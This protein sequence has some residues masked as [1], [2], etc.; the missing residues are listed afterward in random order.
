MDVP[1]CARRRI[2]VHGVESCTGGATTRLV[3]IDDADLDA[4][5]AARVPHRPVADRVVPLLS[6]GLV[7]T[8]AALDPEALCS[9]RSPGEYQDVRA[10]RRLAHG[11]LPTEDGDRPAHRVG[12]AGRRGALTPT[13]GPLSG[14]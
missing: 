7:A 8:R 6:A 1:G 3:D 5:A 10:D 11:Y 12:G 2:Y 13:V 9:A 4:S 14:S